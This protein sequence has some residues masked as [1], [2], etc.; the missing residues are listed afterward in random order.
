MVF[1]GLFQ[2]FVE[3][4]PAGVMHRALLENIFAPEKLNAVFQQAAKIQYQR[5]LL[6]ST[7]DGDTEIHLLTNLPAQVTALRKV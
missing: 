2:R 5:E 6:F 4:S 7:R 1:N 3:A